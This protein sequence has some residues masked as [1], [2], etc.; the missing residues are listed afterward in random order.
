ML[1]IENV[2]ADIL[3]KL[4][5]T[6]TGGNNKSLIQETLKTPSI[7]E[8]ASVVAIEENSSWMASIMQFLLNGVLPNDSIS[9][10]R[11]AK[12]ASYYTIVGGQ[13]YK[14]SLS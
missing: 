13:L 7:A 11:L 6:K 1:R 10:K 12:E 5:S 9:A 3:S 14:R 2:R 4:P 8:P